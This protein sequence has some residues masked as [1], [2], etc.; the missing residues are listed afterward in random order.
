[1]ASITKSI[2]GLFG[3]KKEKKEEKPVEYFD[4][5][6]SKVS[7]FEPGA[8]KGEDF[9]KMPVSTGHGNYLEYL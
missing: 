8:E 2:G 4:V 6:I 9:M 1:M 7:S 5:V 3:S